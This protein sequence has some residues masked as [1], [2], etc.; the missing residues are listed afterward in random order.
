MNAPIRPPATTF[1]PCVERTPAWETAGGRNERAA[2]E[3]ASAD[4]VADIAPTHIAPMPAF[5]AEPLV[6]ACR[7]WKQP[8]AIAM[9]QNC[10]FKFPLR[11]AQARMVSVPSM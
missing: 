2:S 9:S 6:I 4:T 10:T 3:S 1:S 8:H 5:A 11:K 7:T